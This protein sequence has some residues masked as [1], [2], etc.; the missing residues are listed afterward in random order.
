MHYEQQIII[1]WQS[2]PI[3]EP[4]MAVEEIRKI[5]E[6]AMERSQKSAATNS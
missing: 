4:L 1:S 5:T 2:A 3:F 6:A